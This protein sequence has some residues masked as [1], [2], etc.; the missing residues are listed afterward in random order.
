MS[1]TSVSSKLRAGRSPFPLLL[2][3]CCLP[4]GATFL[5]LIRL[6]LPLSL[7]NIFAVQ[8]SQ[9]LHWVIDSV[10]FLIVLLGTGFNQRTSSSATL[11]RASTQGTNVTKLTQAVS[12]LRSDLAKQKRTEE[13]L[14]ASEEFYRN[15]VENANDGIATISLD[16]T[17]TSVNRGIEI[18]LGK[19]R[20]EI[21]GK[22]YSTMLSISSLATIEDRLR[23]FQGGE[24][25]SSLFEMELLHNNGT[26][27]L[28][29]VRTRPIT[30]KDGVTIGF[31]GVYRDVLK[32]SSLT[33]PSPATRPLQS[34]VDAGADVR[35]ATGTFSSSQTSSPTFLNSSF[36]AGSLTEEAFQSPSSAFPSVSSSRHPAGYSPIS[37]QRAE[38]SST[39]SPTFT[40]SSSPEAPPTLPPNDH[41][42]E[43]RYAIHT[44]TTAEP[45]SVSPRFSPASDPSPIQNQ[46]LKVVPFR[47]FGIQNESGYSS[48]STFVSEASRVFDLSEALSRVDG[49]RELLREMAAV[50]LDECPRLVATMHDALSHGNA[51][52]LTYAV[53]TLKGSVGNFAANE[54]YEAVI[55]L[56]RIGKQGNLD[57]AKSALAELE[58][59]LSRLAPMLTTL[60]MEAAA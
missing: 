58:V 35:N 14:R 6:G 39:N 37:Q 19:D 33:N 38:Q 47:A 50:F 36:P 17:I 57:Q 53:H 24:K 49:D 34:R 27:V 44:T 46:P 40:F 31:Q 28:V 52:T 10:P 42:A 54:A 48:S 9:P 32:R 13:T 43:T 5:D 4:L 26:T 45:S 21:V 29:E 56:E 3:A 18:M 1:T 2:V 8:T 60:K 22:H 20:Q 25:L 23:R 59:E 15:L 7:D 30:D 51:Q 16:G 41:P 55:K 12:D 11:T